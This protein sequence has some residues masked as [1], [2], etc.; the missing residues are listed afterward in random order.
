M[1]AQGAM[2][3][4]LA[5]LA[6][7]TYTEPE[8][9]AQEVA[10]DQP[11]QALPESCR[12]RLWAEL[13]QDRNLLR[14]MRRGVCRRVASTAPQPSASRRPSHRADRGYTFGS[15]IRFSGTCEPTPGDHRAAVLVGGR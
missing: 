5:D 14:Q 15:A 1:R 8:L 9:V 12:P 11:P 10:D 6:G 3:D 4:A 13:A 7:Q 2:E